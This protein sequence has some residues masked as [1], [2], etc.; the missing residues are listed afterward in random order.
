LSALLEAEWPGHGKRVLDVACGI[1]TQAIALAM[2]GY[3]V[4]T[5]DLSVKAVERARQEAEKSGV[6]ID[7]S[8]CD[9]RRAHAHH[10]SGFGAVIC[11]DN[12]LPHLLSDQDML[13]APGQMRDCLA[14]GGGCIVTVRD[15]EREARGR[16]LVKSQG[17]RVENDRRSLVFQVWDFEGDHYDLTLCVVEENLST[18]EVTTHSMRSRYYAFRRAGSASSCVRRASRAS[19]ASTARSIS[20]CWWARGA[21]DR[22]SVEPGATGRQAGMPGLCGAGSTG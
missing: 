11:C 2:R 6:A 7:L 21:R 20:R 22:S 5:S 19:S 1:G 16:N 17:A 14:V 18:R 10:G 9:M 13:I 12:S 8:V 3:S 15:Y 4:T